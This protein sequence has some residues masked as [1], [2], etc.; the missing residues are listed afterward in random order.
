MLSVRGM[1]VFVDLI[2]IGWTCDD[3]GGAVHDEW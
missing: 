2:I 3:D 1:V